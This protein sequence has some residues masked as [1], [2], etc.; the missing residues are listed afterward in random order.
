MRGLKKDARISLPR[1]PYMTWYV[2]DIDE[3]R[4]TLAELGAI[5]REAMGR[6]YPAM[7]LIAVKALVEKEAR[8]EIEATAVVPD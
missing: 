2:R 3:Y 8:L 4:A 6:H 1:S 7:A 5:C